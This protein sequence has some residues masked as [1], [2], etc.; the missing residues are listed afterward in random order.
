MNLQDMKLKDLS[1]LVNMLTGAVPAINDESEIVSSY[2]GNLYIVRTC[3]AGVFFGEIVKRNGREVIM[4]NARRLWQW[5]GAA[6]LS[7]LAM[8]GVKNPDGCKF[9]CAVESVELLEVIEILKCSDAAIKSINGVE[10]WKL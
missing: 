5:S 1:C 6:S 10:V 9:P 3:S 8:E 7:Q 2:A 4:R